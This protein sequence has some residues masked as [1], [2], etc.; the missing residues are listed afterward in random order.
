MDYNLADEENW[1]C[2]VD[3]VYDKETKTWTCFKR[4]HVDVVDESRLFE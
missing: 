1:T 3:S 2:S 4:A